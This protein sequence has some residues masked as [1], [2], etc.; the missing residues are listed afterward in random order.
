MKRAVLVTIALFL[1]Y[2]SAFVVVAPPPMIMTSPSVANIRTSEPAMSALSRIAAAPTAALSVMAVVTTSPLRAASVAALGVS[3]LVARE[4]RQ[5]AIAAEKEAEK[6]DISW[7]PL[8]SFA[9]TAALA[10]TD[11][12]TSVLESVQD[13]NPSTPKVA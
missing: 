1:A 2:T 3:L 9:G 10:I 5:A 13:A 4:R 6:V 7:D 11:V 8:V 12:A